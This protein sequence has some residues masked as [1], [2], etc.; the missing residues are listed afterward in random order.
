MSFIS[1]LLS[2][3]L[4]SSWVQRGKL[5][6]SEC[7]LRFRLAQEREAHRQ[8]IKRLIATERGW[9][10]DVMENMW[11]YGP[12]HVTSV[13]LARTTPLIAATINTWR[14]HPLGDCSHCG[15]RAPV[16][17]RTSDISPHGSSVKVCAWGCEPSEL[18]LMNYENNRRHS[19]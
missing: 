11:G 5:I 4:G 12:T 10:V 9:A 14:V 15:K 13:A 16:V 8:T 3:A 7:K 1:L 17:S 18:E 2:K 19:T 6:Q